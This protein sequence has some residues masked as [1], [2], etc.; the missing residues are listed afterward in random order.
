M[1]RWLWNVLIS[2]DQTVGV[3]LSPVLNLV[4]NPKHKFGDP[5][6]TMSSVMG[7]NVRNG[8]CRG[9]YAIC[10]ILHLLDPDHCKKSIEDDE[11]IK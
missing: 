1:K 2:I 8:S 5:D 11:G 10:K 9:C 7:K 3:I 4:M 6:E